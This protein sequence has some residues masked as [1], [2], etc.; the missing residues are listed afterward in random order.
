MLNVPSG[1]Q[2]EKNVVKGEGAN[3]QQS[4]SDALEIREISSNVLIEISDLKVRPNRS[5][6]DE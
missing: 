1:S 5:Q 4:S 6:G 2:P 3:N